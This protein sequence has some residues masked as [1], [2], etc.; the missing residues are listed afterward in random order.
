MN[1]LKKI[2]LL[3]IIAVF[4]SCRGER[5]D[6]KLILPKQDYTGNKLRVDGYYYREADGRYDILF[7]YR[8]GTTLYGSAPLVSEIE[9]MENS[10]ANGEY[11][12]IIK[13]IKHDWGRFIVDGN[14]FTRE[15]WQPSSGGP[16]D[17]YTHSGT[18]LN[19]TTFQITQ[20]WRSCKP[21]KKNDLDR[22]YHFKQFSPK[23]DSTNAY[24]N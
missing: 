3:S 15:F 12:S 17:A 11:Y 1:L 9:S 21:K 20:A 10:Y 22:I 4:F 18:I 5:W 23:P 2:L 8:D 14:S 6:D 24:T 16:L 19:D 7:L 13:D